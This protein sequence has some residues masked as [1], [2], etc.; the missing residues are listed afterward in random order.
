[1]DKGDK[2]WWQEPDGDKFELP[3]DYDKLKWFE[4]KAVREQYVIEQQNMCYYCDT[5]L[6]QDAPEYIIEKRIDWDLFPPNFLRHPIH[7]Q[8]DHYTGMTEGAV[9]AYC[10]AVMWQYENK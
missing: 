2:K 3:V 10:N 1:M 8:H 4:R 9:H 7:L 5:R 6:D